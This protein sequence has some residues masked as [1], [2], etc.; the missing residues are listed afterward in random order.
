MVNALQHT[1]VGL[2]SELGSK[3]LVLLA[4]DCNYASKFF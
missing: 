3:V 2:M 1:E 4:G